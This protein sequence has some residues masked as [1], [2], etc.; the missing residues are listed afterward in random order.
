MKRKL[1]SLLI[2]AVLLIGIAPTVLAAEEVQ[3]EA[4]LMYAD[5]GWKYQ[6][7]NDGSESDIV[8]TKATITG[9]GTY[10]VG[11][12]FSKTED[13]VA[14]GLAFTA[15]GIVN[16]ETTMPGWCIEIKSIR[17]NGEEI[18]FSKGYTSSDDGVVTRMNVYNEW[19]TELPED[20]RSYDGKISDTSPVIVDK[21]DFAEVTT[22]EIMFE[23]SEG[24]PVEAFLM[25]ADA[26]WTYQYWNDGAES[27]IVATKATIKGAGEYTVGLDFSNTAD[28]AASGLAFAAV[29]INNG[30][31][32]RSGY[33]ITISSIKI[34]G[35]DIEFTKGYT[36]SDDG[37]V[38][39][40]NIYNEWVAEL[41]EDARSSDGDTT[42]ASWIIVDKELFDSVKTIE[43]TFRYAPPYFGPDT[44]FI[45]YADSA[46]GL[47][48]WG[49]PVD[50]GI[51]TTDAAV[52]GEGNYTVALDFTETADGKAADVAFAALGI[53][54]GEQT[55]PGYTIKIKS[56]K[57][58][59]AD[60][61][62]TKGYTS[63]DEG[64]V[65]RMNIFNEWVTELPKDAR[66]Y[67]G[68][69]DD[70]GWIIVDKTAFKDVE[71]IEINFDYIYAP[72]EK[73]EEV[74]EIDI[75]AALAA[76]YD[77]Y[78]GVQTTSYIFRNAWSDSYGIETANWTHLTGWDADG[79]EVDYGGSFTD[80]KIIGNGTYTVSV[81]LGD[82]GFGTDEA[83]RMLFAS[84]NIPSKLIDDG[85]VKIEN[86]SVSFDGG[87]AAEFTYVDTK[88]DYA[89]IALINEYNAEV[90][91]E[92]VAYSAMPKTGI[93]ITFTISG[94]TKDADAPEATAT[95]A[96]TQAPA[97]EEPDSE[98][99]GLST[100]AIVAI[101]VGGV[102][103]IGGGSAGAM[104]LK[105]KS[106]K[107]PK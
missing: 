41:P 46:W 2:A 69:V 84:T 93:E 44:A 18:E 9:A 73:V 23:L 28:K 13:K 58:N 57:I 38:T 92:T 16:G 29:G 81:T 43:V 26:N 6:Y 89:Q 63:T 104:V 42:D 53:L 35:K 64:V 52:E 60:V 106:K 101:V 62:F 24:M 8:A 5:A 54:T 103:A 20:A 48:Y 49:E 32:A 19:V 30:E 79:N 12:D 10:T 74:V 21:E 39:R 7:W 17:I 34:N 61:P 11:L 71:T 99:D 65:T 67:D 95:P 4:Y 88:G 102:V 40:M 15:I 45:M 36:S 87:K 82:M 56:F 27:D 75:E 96:P 90:G 66:S 51:I 98:K 77:A 1:L 83:F 55:H 85:L 105:K 33:C 31:T 86:V 22:V 25:Y 78:F 37:I 68:K 3:D 107:S 100:G 97:V 70:S 47:Q 91:V 14:S 80:A 94:L 50:T 76:D 59:G 72:P